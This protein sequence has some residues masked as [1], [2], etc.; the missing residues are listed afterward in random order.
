MTEEEALRCFAR[1]LN[2]LD[3]SEVQD[4]LCEDVLYVLEDIEAAFAGKAAVVQHLVT[5]IASIKEARPERRVYAELGATPEGWKC[6]IQIGRASC[7]ER[8]SL[9]V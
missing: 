9:H 5:K 7:R 4:Y 6:I 3:V 2:R 8:V 1:A